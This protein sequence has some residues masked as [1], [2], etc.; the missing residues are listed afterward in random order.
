[1]GSSGIWSYEVIYRLFQIGGKTSR[2]ETASHAV[3]LPFEKKQ[4]CRLHFL[5]VF[6]LEACIVS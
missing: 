3:V 5:Q 6:R 4:L 2:V 1:M